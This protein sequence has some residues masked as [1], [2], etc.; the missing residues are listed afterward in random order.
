MNIIR[1]RRSLWFRLENTRI[2]LVKVAMF[3][4]CA[5]ISGMAFEFTYRILQRL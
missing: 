1:T 5:F 3:V 2:A 4:V